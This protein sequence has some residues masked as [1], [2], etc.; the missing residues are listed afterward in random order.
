MILDLLNSIEEIR[1]VIKE[2]VKSDKNGYIVLGTIYVNAAEVI[3]IN[4][5]TVY[6][7]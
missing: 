3:A 1:E 4:F 5:E 2:A 6:E 7:E